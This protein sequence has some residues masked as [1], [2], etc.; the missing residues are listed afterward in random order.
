M[1]IRFM[2]EGDGAGG[3]GGDAGGDPGGGDQGAGTTTIDPN[4]VSRGTQEPA[5]FD[6][7]NWKQGLSEDIRD[8]KEFE[9]YTEF[10]TF[11]K[12]HL[13]LVKMVGLDSVPKPN[14]EFGPDDQ[15][16][17]QWDHVFN[18]LGRPDDPSG[19]TFPKLQLPEGVE[20][21][22]EAHAAQVAEWHKL[23]F[24]QAQVN[25][26]FKSHHQGRVDAHN[27]N[28]KRITDLGAST[29]IELK[30]EWGE[31]Y[32]KE[33]NTAIRAI[34]EFGND[35]VK[36]LLNSSGLGNNPVM[37]K[38]FNE[39]GKAIMEDTELVGGGEGKRGG[40]QT[41]KE[42]DAQIAE[43][44][45]HPARKNKKHAENKIIADK[46]SV[47]FKKKADFKDKQGVIG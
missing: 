46:L 9:K 39:I 27:A 14:G 21:S 24:N 36:E 1:F 34:G 12:S 30:K 10:D 6:S 42:I 35:E 32:Q 8:N 20:F 41:P 15:N 11:A 22:K 17:E 45:G 5:A 38:F 23:G 29:E 3:G 40:A 26:L 25:A 7:A 43:L 44:Q 37:L 33:V 2:F 47:L 16:R 4:D 13:N 19:Y 18:Q 31:A 28:I